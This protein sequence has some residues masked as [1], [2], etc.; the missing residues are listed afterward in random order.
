MGHHVSAIG[1]VVQVSSTLFP[2]IPILATARANALSRT[3]T[4]ELVRLAQQGDVAA[5]QR[6]IEGHAMMIPRAIR[7]YFAPQL[8]VDNA[9]LTSSDLFQEAVLGLHAAIH[10]YDPSKGRFSTYAF[11]WI[12][13]YVSRALDNQ[14]RVIRLPAHIHHQCSTEA[15]RRGISPA[16]VVSLRELPVA[17][18]WFDYPTPGQSDDLP[19]MAEALPDERPGTADDA[20]AAALQ[21]EVGRSLD[22]LPEKWATVLRLRFGLEGYT[23][24]TRPAIAARMGVSERRI[25]N[26][27]RDALA[28]MQTLMAGWE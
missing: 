26:I 8:R 2:D 14:E 10:K 4:A 12:R 20:T 3:E 23:E 24:I 25:R 19:T 1:G 28:K 21:N 6:L 5:E 18:N 17:E 7:K 11:P 27:E 16:E 22:L 9:C 13:A 15:R